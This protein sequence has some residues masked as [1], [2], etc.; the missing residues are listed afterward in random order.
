MNFPIALDSTM[1]AT[2]RACGQKFFRE[3]LEHWKAK[4]PSINL[5]AGVAYAKGLETARKAFYEKGLKT[6]DA[7]AL[8]LE[9]LI[10]AYG[11]FDSGDSAKSLER[12][13]GALEFYFTCYPLEL[14]AATPLI[15]P[16]GSR[17]I[18]FSFAIP[19]PIAHPETGD[20]ILYCG[21]MD[22][23]TSFANGI[24]GL[25]DK[26]TSS[27]GPSWAKQW[28]L[29]SQFIG[30][31]WAAREAGIDMSGFLVRGVS[32]LKTKYDTQQAMVNISPFLIDRWYKQLL[33]DVHDIV[34]DW[35]LHKATSNPDAWSFNLDHSCAEYGGCAFTRICESPNP[36]NWLPMTF[37]KRVW[38][39]LDRS[40]KELDQ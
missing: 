8:G 19:L 15:L 3:Y 4:A 20:P 12:M 22:M 29:R 6:S 1:I 11:D 35:K 32:I 23:I 30:Y 13:C 40:E 16:N 34:H 17:A 14:D 31:T 26:T 27:L 7:E 18:E 28:Q 21:R 37:T 33:R 10:K 5:H 9:A 39:P 38:N 36:E 2:Y 25:D 24:Y